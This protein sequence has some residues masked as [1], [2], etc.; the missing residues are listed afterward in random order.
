MVESG[1]KNINGFASTMDVD[2]CGRTGWTWKD[3]AN[4]DG[5]GRTERAFASNLC[6]GHYSSTYAIIV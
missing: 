5:R 2:G 6:T 4:L 1:G 3:G